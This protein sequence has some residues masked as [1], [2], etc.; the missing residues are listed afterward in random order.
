MKVQLTISQVS[1][2]LVINL[3]IQYIVFHFLFKFLLIPHSR[4][5]NTKIGIILVRLLISERLK[6]RYNEI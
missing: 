6:C 3:Y 5:Q 4:I 1:I 2:Y